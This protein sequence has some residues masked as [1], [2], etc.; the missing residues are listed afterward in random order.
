MAGRQGRGPDPQALVTKVGGI[1]TKE[2]MIYLCAI[3]AV[4]LVFIVVQQNNWVKWILLASFASI[5]LYVGYQMVTK[6][7]KV[8]NYRLGLAIIL[9]LSSVVFWSL[10]EQAGSSLS[11]L[12][13]RNIDLNIISS[14]QVFDVFGQKL[15][16][17]TKDQL[18]AL[19]LNGAPH[20]FVDM[21]IT[22]SNTQSFNPFFILIF[23]PIFAYVFTF[24]SRHRMD[25]DP[26]KKFSFGLVC[27]GLSFLVLVYGAAFKDDSFKLPLIF[28]LTTYLLQTWGELAIS[29]V[30]LSQT[31]KLSPITLIG[32]MMAVWFLG[33]SGGQYL[34]G[35]IA[36]MSGTETAGG[37]VLD[38]RAALETSMNTFSTIGTW[39][40]GLGLGLFIASFFLKDW[41]HG[42][43]EAD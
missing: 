40:I 32:T 42:I 16:F 43:D 1:L 11:L 41:A 34:A 24:L 19:A 21:E 25:P 39:A 33:L 5:M 2:W 10:F 20:F 9:T 26:V 18:Q 31:S 23:T 38:A 22:A 14:A 30:G 17:G 13:S 3:V 7:S 8:E 35:A 12:A 29:P 4:P 28:L 15:I 6:Y 37:K 36:S 27:A